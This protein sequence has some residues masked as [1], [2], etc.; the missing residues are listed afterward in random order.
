MT[1][2]FDERNNL[3]GQP[4]LH[5]LIVG[6]S[7]YPHLPG[8]TGKLARDH[9]GLAQ[10]PSSV[11]SAYKIYRWLVERERQ[12][13]LPV[14]LATCRLLL[15]P[16]PPALEMES[17]LTDQIASCTLDHFLIAA[18]HWRDDASTQQDNITFFYFAGYD[19]QKSEDEEILLVE[20]FGD[21]I[22]GTLRNAVGI[23]NLFNGMAPHHSRPSMA[24]TQI[25][26]VDVCRVLPIRPNQRFERMNTTDVFDPEFIEFDN[27]S[28]SIFYA[29]I[30][31]GQA[32]PLQGDLTLFSKP[33]LDC[34]NGIAGERMDEESQSQVKW[35]VS[36]NSLNKALEAYFKELNRKLDIHL[37]Y[38]LKRGA[39]GTTISYLETPPPVKTLVFDKRKAL[40][41]QP[42]LHALIVGVSAYPHLP[43]GTG[44]LARD[45]FGLRQ[46]S[47]AALTAYKISCWLQEQQNDLAAPLATCRLLL[48]PSPAELKAEPKL[49]D[50]VD[51]CTLANF[52]AA[53]IEWRE[54]ANSHPDNITF[55]Y[56]AGHGLQ[57][58]SGDQVLLMENFGD[59]I[60]GAL[61]N[62]VEISNLSN[63]M[64]SLGIQRNIALT[65]L[66]FVD[67]CSS[68]S[69]V[70]QKYEW[71]NT[72]TVWDVEQG[73][74]DDRRAPTFYAA[75]PG[76]RAYG[77]KGDQTIFSKALL[78]CLDGGASDLNEQDDQWY[79]SANSLNNALDHYIR[80]L[81]QTTGAEQNYRAIGLGTDVVIRRLNQTP[82]VNFVLEVEPLDALQVTKVEVEYLDGDLKDA[83]GN[84]FTL[85]VPLTPHPYKRELPGGHY[86]ISA[87]IIP[88][89]QRFVDFPRKTFTL[90]P[91]NPKWTVKV[92][93]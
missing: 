34:L 74:S 79:I 23:N 66:Y 84:P 17:P 3:Q 80:E 75:L 87:K 7:A 35:R 33:L 55:F 18:K 70:F 56:F 39:E 60:G 69:K 67:A 27:R 62:A 15:S 86:R 61:R 53:A 4:G 25:Y 26:F 28:A 49:R 93:P 31:G 73:I 29:A 72:S 36:V 24:R 37:D 41:G 92:S 88:V 90:K 71:M 5:A 8:G 11:S 48:S 44:K 20:N 1:L 12:K 83:A 85:P 51:H 38:K 6:V 2:V 52:L 43:E 42:G 21:G 91:T 63:G 10:L 68:Y 64:A 13:Y 54:D 19:L 40:Q 16:S 77:I 9:F 65:Q 30:R 50:L 14:P 78:Q 81:N 76:H 45:H 89:D 46:L 47:S 82:S 59:G 22:G 58:E 32:D 57:R